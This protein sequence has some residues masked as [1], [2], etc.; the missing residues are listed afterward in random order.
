MLPRKAL[1]GAALLGLVACASDQELIGETNGEKTDDDSA[2]MGDTDTDTDTDVTSCIPTS[3]ELTGRGFQKYVATLAEGDESLSMGNGASLKYQGVVEVDGEDQAQ[4]TVVLED[5]T[6]VQF[7]L[8]PGSCYPVG[9]DEASQILVEVAALEVETSD[10]GNRISK[11]SYNV[12]Y[13]TDLGVS[14]GD[15]GD[16]T[17]LADECTF[18]PTEGVNYGTG[19]VYLL[20]GESR[21][22]EEADGSWT[23]VGFQPVSTGQTTHNAAQGS[24]TTGLTGGLGECVMGLGTRRLYGVITALNIDNSSADYTR[25]GITFSYDVGPTTQ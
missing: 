18:E 2:Q 10:T 3:D 9:E 1:A 24:E 12:F 20:P 14:V 15:V 25:V 5:G 23:Y 16:T 11:A 8:A 7:N 22:F 19:V 4:Q 17:T 21:A 13:Y 6:S